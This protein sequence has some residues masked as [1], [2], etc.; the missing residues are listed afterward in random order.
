[1]HNCNTRKKDGDTRYAGP[2]PAGATGTAGAFGNNFLEAWKVNSTKVRIRWIGNTNGGGFTAN[3]G[4][5]ATYQIFNVT[6]EWTSALGGSNDI[7]T[8]SFSTPAYNLADNGA[9]RFARQNMKLS[10]YYG[11]QNLGT[12]GG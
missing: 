4:G 2:T 6:P 9:V 3:T 7:G 8:V 11:T 1:M 10:D 5:P 12:D